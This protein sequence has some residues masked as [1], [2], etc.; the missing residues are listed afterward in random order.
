MKIG[1][2][3]YTFYEI[4]HRV[5]RYAEVL[6]EQGHEVDAIVLREKGQSPKD[7]LNGVNLYRIQ[8]RKYNEKNLFDYVFRIGVFFLKGSLLLIRRQIS[9]RYDLLHI[10]SVPDFLIY[11]GLVPKMLGAKLILDIHDM[12]P[13]FYAQKFRR[14]ISSPL[15]KL[16]IL[17]E[18]RCVRYAHHTIAANDLWRNKIIHRDKIEPERCTTLLN[19]PNLRFLK[20]MPLKENGEELNIVYPGTISHHHGI[21]VAVRALALVKKIIKNVQFDIYTR[22]NNVEYFRSLSLLIRELDLEDT[23]KIH[24][25]VPS[26]DLGRIFANAT[27]GVVPKRGGVFADEAFSTKIFDFMAVGLPIIASRT[28]IDEYYFDDSTIMFFRPED[29]EDLA[30]CVLELFH[31]KERRLDLVKHG[32]D[33]IAVNNWEM[34]STEYIKIVHSLVNGR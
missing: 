33:F 29:H 16:L 3:A 20:A 11:M 25:P 4:D 6:A 17:I 1:V 21:D 19:Y 24:D 9:S 28:K 31:N 8:E 7:V 30:R 10:N 13:E 2:I 12:L 23:V 22:S 32:H 27:M 14:D 15:V 18:K 34:K 26:E 5:R